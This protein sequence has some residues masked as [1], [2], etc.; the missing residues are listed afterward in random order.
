MI[1]FKITEASVIYALKWKMVL[2]K[3]FK[4]LANLE[5]QP[6]P[7]RSH[8]ETNSQVAMSSPGIGR[9]RARSGPVEETTTFSSGLILK[10]AESEPK[11]LKYVRDLSSSFESETVLEEGFDFDEKYS[12]VKAEHILD[13]QTY[14]LKKRWI[15]VSQDQE[16]QD[17]PAYE[18]ILSVKDQSQNLNVRYVTSWVE[19]DPEMEN[20]FNFTE[21]SGVH[22]ILYIQFR[23]VTNLLK[24]GKDLIISNSTTHTFDEDL[25]YDMAEDAV[26]EARKYEAAGTALGDALTQAFSKIGLPES[27]NVTQLNQ[28]VWNFCFGDAI[29]LN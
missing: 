15:W 27:S 6:S 18:E 25:V 5:D 2:A 20:Q 11:V 4:S 8:G 3:K 29:E 9:S 13:G 22:V 12:F 21:S 10:A 16:I 14:I 26:K 1:A 23:Y 28:K 24:L 19:K 17:H 7:F